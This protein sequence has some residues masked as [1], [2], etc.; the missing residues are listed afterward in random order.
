M[1]RSTRYRRP[2]RGNRASDS[3]AWPRRGS[4]PVCAGEPRQTAS[5]PRRLGGLS[6][7]TRGNLLCCSIAGIRRGP[8]PAYAGE[9]NRDAHSPDATGVYPRLRGGTATTTAGTSYL[10]GLS[11]PARGNPKQ[12]DGGYKKAGPI[13]ACAGEPPSALIRLHWSGA[14]PR[15]RGGTSGRQHIEFT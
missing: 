1:P 14:Y 8:I 4:I 9:P 15:L 7:P 12:D 6:P 3:A 10:T 13:P 11:P 2:A 5:A